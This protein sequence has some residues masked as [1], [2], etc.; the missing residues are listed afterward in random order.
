MQPDKI[1]DLLIQVWNRYHLP[2][3][4]TENG[5]ADSED[6][7]RE[8]FIEE[9]MK[10]LQRAEKS[11]VDVRGY[12]HWSL[13]DNFEWDKGYWPKFGLVSVEVKTN[14]RS[15]RNSAYSLAK[16]AKKYLGFKGF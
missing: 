13:L 9:T 5:L 1:G 4:I 12:L 14:K 6:R 16:Y 8:W 2:I 10:S 11:G 3:V 7:Y 15:V